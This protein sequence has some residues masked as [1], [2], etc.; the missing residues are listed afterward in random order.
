LHG[1]WLALDADKCEKFVE[2]GVRIFAQVTRFF[3]DRNIAP[4]LK[5]ANEVKKEID[6][7]R[8]KVPLMVALRK[9]GMK[10]R[11]W[12]QISDVC[13]FEVQPGEDYTFTK[14]LDMGLLEFTNQCQEVGE[15]AY[16]E[17]LIETELAAMKKQ[18]EDIVLELKPYVKGTTNTFVIRGYDDI[19]T[20]LDD[21]IV[22]TQAMQFS[23]FKKP[24]EEEI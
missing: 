14:I 10:D 11:H 8:P 23:P 16:K 15:R 9:E 6:D 2:D 22:K 5:I 13:G 19:N 12:K 21:H 4:V 3:K 7:F 20:V 18:W 24:F 17:Y 1:R